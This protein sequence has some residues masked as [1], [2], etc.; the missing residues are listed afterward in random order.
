[1]CISMTV[2][3]KEWKLSQLNGE[4][5]SINFRPT[6]GPQ[7]LPSSVSRFREFYIVIKTDSALIEVALNVLSLYLVLNRLVKII[8]R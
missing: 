7:N 5:Y 1:M 6:T 3:G 2:I 4:F 8:R